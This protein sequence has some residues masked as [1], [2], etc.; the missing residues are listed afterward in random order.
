MKSYI[1]YRRR[2]VASLIRRAVPLPRS[3]RFADYLGDHFIV[4]L[5]DYRSYVRTAVIRWMSCIVARKRDDESD[6]QHCQYGL[7]HVDRTIKE[8]AENIWHID[9]RGCKIGSHDGACGPRF[10]CV[11]FEKVRNR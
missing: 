11:Y 6:A 8:Y 7:L 2:L 3:G 9:P 1:R 4:V 10:L 5:A